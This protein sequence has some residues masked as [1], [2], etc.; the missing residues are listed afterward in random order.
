VREVVLHQEGRGSSPNVEVV[1]TGLDPQFT[2]LVISINVGSL[3][4]RILAGDWD[5]DG[6]DGIAIFCPLTLGLVF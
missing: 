4:G 3:T 6:K 2:I 1:L 5:R